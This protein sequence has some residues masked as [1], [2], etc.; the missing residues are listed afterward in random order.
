MAMDF[1]VASGPLAT[2]KEQKTLLAFGRHNGEIEKLVGCPRI[3]DLDVRASASHDERV[4]E[5][6][7]PAMAVLAEQL[8]ECVALEALGPHCASDANVNEHRRLEATTAFDSIDSLDK[9]GR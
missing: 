1:A 8:L 4:A 7:H 9:L 5:R 2:A 3:G 6:F